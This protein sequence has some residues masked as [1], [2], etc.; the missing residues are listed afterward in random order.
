MKKYNYFIPDTAVF[1]VLHRSQDL[2]KQFNHLFHIL[3]RDKLKELGVRPVIQGIV[4][5]IILATVWCLA[6]HFEIIKCVK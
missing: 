6:I 1:L 5:W 3:N 2:D 4:L